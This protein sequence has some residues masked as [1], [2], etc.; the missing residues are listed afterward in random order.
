MLGLV[1]QQIA[2][3]SPQSSGDIIHRF[4]YYVTSPSVYDNLITRLSAHVLYI[5]HRRFN[6]RCFVVHKHIK[7]ALTG[8]NVLWK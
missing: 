6:H 7:I 2:L 3:K 1:R 5:V 4:V 8:H